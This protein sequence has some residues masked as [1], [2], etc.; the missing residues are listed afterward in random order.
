M[1]QILSELGRRLPQIALG[2]LA[3]KQGGPQA[4]AAF[5]GGL[6]DAQQQ[7]QALARQAQLD[8]ERRQAMAAQESRAS[9]AD[10]RASEAAGRADEDRRLQRLQAALQFL[11]QYGGTLTET[12]TDPEAA[13]QQ[14]VSQA[15]GLEQTF[16]IPSGQLT[17]LVPQIAPQIS[18]R[19]QR[20]A[21]E[22]YAKA[23]KLYGADAMA[24]D[25]ITIQTE[26]F[27]PVTPSELRALF[28]PPAFM[29]PAA[30]QSPPT[31][32]VGPIP[33]PIVTAKPDVPNTPEEQFY[34]TFAEEHDT[35]WAQLSRTL[36]A[37][38]RREWMQAD[39]RPRE[40]DPSIT[41]GRRFTMEQRLA[42]QWERAAGP[43]REM[44][45]QLGLMETGLRR[46]RQGDKNG[47]SQAVLVTF[48]KILDPTSVVRESEYAR[49]ATGQSLLNRIQ[50]YSERLAAGGAGLTDAELALMVGT[51]QEFLSGMSNFNAGTRR[52]LEVTAKEYQLDPRMIFDD[53]DVN[54]IGAT[55]GDAVGTRRIGRFE[56]VDEQ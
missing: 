9:S 26:A 44:R 38:A 17:P 15:T 32:S 23:E 50:G 24:G 40:I 12:A 42:T 47:G 37:Q 52:R 7:Q 10:Q 22:T 4:L 41:A 48:Q 2:F 11:N 6:L 43:I 46:F 3:A 35:T 16:G 29:A 1:S 51:A 27:G 14:L 55:S 39:D 30:G 56:I 8:E 18:K 13:Q 53:V 34:A 45:R 49:T 31:D 33:A 5:Q 54:G 19:K 36:K 28:A 20:L 25:S 21:E